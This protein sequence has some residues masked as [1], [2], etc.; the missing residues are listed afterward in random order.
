MKCDNYQIIMT[1]TKPQSKAIQIISLNT[2]QDSIRLVVLFE[3]GEIWS[4][5]SGIL[6]WNQIL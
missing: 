2:N 1:K 6:H 5:D 4:Y 3:N